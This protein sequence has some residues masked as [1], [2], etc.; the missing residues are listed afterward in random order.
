MHLGF[1]F[2]DGYRDSTVTESSTKMCSIRKSIVPVPFPFSTIIFLHLKIDLLNSQKSEIPISRLS[3]YP[4][5]TNGREK[6]NTS[7]PYTTE[8]AYS[9]PVGRFILER[10]NTA[11]V[12]RLGRRWYTRYHSV[13]YHLA[14]C[15]CV[16]SSV[17]VHFRG[18]RRMMFFSEGVC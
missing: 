12:V 9:V 17:Y 18:C 7:D 16:V 14:N 8:F 2:N 11:T 1:T 13:V 6:N 4:T 3:S 10:P 5:F 15:R